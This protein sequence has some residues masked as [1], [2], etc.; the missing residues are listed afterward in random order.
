MNPHGR[1]PSITG[2][3]EGEM[4]KLRI[5]L[6]HAVGFPPEVDNLA[7]THHIDSLMRPVEGIN[8]EDADFDLGAVLRQIGIHP[9]VNVYVNW[10]RYDKID[11]I[12]F[13]DLAQFLPWVWYPSA[14]DIEVFDETCSWIVS[15][16]HR[17]DIGYLILDSSRLGALDSQLGGRD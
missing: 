14:D 13:A 16:A 6:A 7:L 2:V 4:R 10:Y 11:E 1:F 3:P 15:I 17:G 12:A 8:A 5:R 9:L